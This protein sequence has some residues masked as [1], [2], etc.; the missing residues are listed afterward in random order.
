MMVREANETRVISWLS[1]PAIELSEMVIKIT[2][3]AAPF[4]GQIRLIPDNVRLDFALVTAGDL[5]DEVGVGGGLD[6]NSLE[7]L[8]KN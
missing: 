5:G 6:G 3:R 1:D 2:A 8:I 4:C 7:L